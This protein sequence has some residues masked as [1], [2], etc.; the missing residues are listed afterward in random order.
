MTFLEGGI[1]SEPQPKKCTH[2]GSRRLV[3]QVSVIGSVRPTFMQSEIDDKRAAYRQYMDSPETRKKL[4]SGE[5]E[6]KKTSHISH[7]PSTL[8]QRLDKIAPKLREIDR[9]VDEQIAN[10]KK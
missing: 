3:R 2:C 8:N 1:L 4:D 7:K 6:L 9:K 5:L 10:A